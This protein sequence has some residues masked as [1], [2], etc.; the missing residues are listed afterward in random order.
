MGAFTF[1]A[2]VALYRMLAV[3]SQ[4]EIIN[5]WDIVS[6]FIQ[7]LEAMVTTKLGDYYFTNQVDFLRYV[8][9]DIVNLLQH[10]QNHPISNAFPLFMNRPG[11]V[12]IKQNTFLFEIIS[13]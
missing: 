9:V 6:A 12:K 13:K 2:L 11:S 4:Y 8:L 3:F 10:L 5:A 1:R 7:I